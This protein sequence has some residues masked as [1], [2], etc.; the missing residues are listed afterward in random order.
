MK[1]PSG[2][3]GAPGASPAQPR[4][5]P[6]RASTV[7]SVDEVDGPGAL[8]LRRGVLA[9]SVL[10]DVDVEPGRLGLVLPGAPPV[11]ISWGECARVLGGVDPAGAQ[12]RRLLRAHLR[13]RRW[14]ADLGPTALAGRLRPAGLPVGHA[15]HPG[16]DWVCSPVLGGALDL[17]LA[18]VG[19]DPADPEG[20]V[21][22]PRVL[23]PAV[24]LDPDLAW[25]DARDLL[26]DTGALAL[27]LLARDG[28]HQLRP[29][30]ECDAVTLLGARSLRR[31]LAEPAGG[32]L[33]VV[34]PMRRRG[35]TRI[36]LVDPAFG[37]AAAAATATEERG[38]PRPLLVTADEVSMVPQGGRPQAT[39]VTGGRDVLPFR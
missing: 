9:V 23:L 25:S 38:F 16:P 14:A 8:Q 24:G 20:L 22:L 21:L 27:D 39:A 11:G 7:L 37:P 15:L 36:G 4:P 28:R 12:G 34:V 2:R 30:G 1:R 6:H 5:G 31:G 3:R 26:E 19:L 33:G 13:A 29:V 18:A 32:L 35:W 17:G 10:D